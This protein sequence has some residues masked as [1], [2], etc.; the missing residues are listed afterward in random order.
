MMPP[1]GGGGRAESRICTADLN[2]RRLAELSSTVQG[3][4]FGVQ[5][6]PPGGAGAGAGGAG[7]RNP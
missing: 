2:A 6:L 5:V 4:I 1:G 3:E 7:E